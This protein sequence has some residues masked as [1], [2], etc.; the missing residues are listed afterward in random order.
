MTVSHLDRPMYLLGYLP[1]TQRA[2]L[3]DKDHSVVTYEV[4]I[5]VLEYQTAVMR[6]DF[7]A[8]DAVRH[9]HLTWTT[10]LRF[11]SICHVGSTHDPKATT[12]PCCKVP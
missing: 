11:L 2:Y 5:S 10:V 7:E 12:G 1:S 4:H 9:L 8:A 3:G 6:G